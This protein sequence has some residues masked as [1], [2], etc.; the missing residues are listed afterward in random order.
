MIDCLYRLYPDKFKAKA[1]ELTI[2]LERIFE[3][4][5]FPI[6]D[7]S[8][9]IIE[10]SYANILSNDILSRLN[11]LFHSI[12]SNNL[13]EHFL[14]KRYLPRPS[15]KSSKKTPT[16]ADFFSGAGGLSQGLI[17][18]GAIPAFVNDHYL[19]A[20][21][22]H[23]FN[24]NLTLDRYFGGDIQ[25][26]IDNFSDF[27][28]KLSNVNIVVGGPPCQGFSMANRQP[29]IN[30][31]RNV[32]Y[33]DFIYLLQLIQPDFFIME[34]VP[35]MKRKIKEIEKDVNEI[36]NGDYRFTELFLNAKDFG[37]PQNRERYFLIG[38]KVG[39]SNLKLE[40]DILVNKTSKP[41]CL[42][43]ALH[44]LPKIGNNPHRMNTSYESD[45]NGYYMTRTELFRNKFL[46]EINKGYSEDFIFNH[47]SR[48]NQKRDIEIFSKLPQGGNSLHE[49]I[50]DLM[51]YKNRDNVF[52][53]K[54]YKLEENKVSK[55]ITSHMR[56]D[57]NSYIHPT[58]AR[59]LSPREAAR[60]QT[61]ADD[62][63]FRGTLND[64]YHQIGNAV[65]VRLAE[66]I[67]TEI[68]KYYI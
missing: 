12:Q 22:T 48:Y 59:G 56:L 30:D 4:E 67:G 44:G 31:P 53:D 63:I 24:H 61:F 58:Q 29:L 36:A 41:Y 18:S 6:I 23:Y 39:Y 33:K 28:S 27:S 11:R 50:R 10:K 40:M 34:N 52:K 3:L 62:Y 8:E 46:E 2:E 1:A 60:I 16:F 38:N 5:N 9:I 26:I 20:I 64:W 32:L 13:N 35:G 15:F 17:N 49:S 7:T 55:T 37:I 54:Y 51:P 57:C 42:K 65:P 14:L 43:D 21:E 68:M 66:I 25:E 47:K 45:E 19:P